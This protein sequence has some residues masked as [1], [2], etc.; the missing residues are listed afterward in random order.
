MDKILLSLSRPA[1]SK[2]LGW[3]C[4][5]MQILGWPSLGSKGVFSQHIHF[6]QHNSQLKPSSTSPNFGRIHLPQSKAHMCLIHPLSGDAAHVPRAPS[7][8]QLP[9]LDTPRAQSLPRSSLPLHP[10]PASSGAP[11]KV[12]PLIQLPLPPIPAPSPEVP[13]PTVLLDTGKS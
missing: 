3:S 10:S 8:I 13:P 5:E 12:P 4:H 9:L 6:P 7:R 2:D 1:G 11:L